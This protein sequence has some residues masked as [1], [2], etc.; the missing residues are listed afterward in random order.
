M[1]ERSFIDETRMSVWETP[2]K[3][4]EGLGRRE[5]GYHLIIQM[6]CD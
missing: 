6:K 2:V 5:G 1:H 4:A 3:D